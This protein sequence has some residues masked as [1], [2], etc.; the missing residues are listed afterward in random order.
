M[1]MR[2]RMCMS[3]SWT[4]MCMHIPMAPYVCCVAYASQ[5]T[6]IRKRVHSAK[7]NAP[8]LIPKKPFFLR[9]R[10]R[11]VSK[12]KEGKRRA[13]SILVTATTGANKI[14]EMVHEMASEFK[15]EGYPSTAAQ[16]VDEI[17]L[18]ILSNASLRQQFELAIANFC[19]SAEVR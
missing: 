18:L 2:M 13:K 19:S 3:M 6:M 11:G 9:W 5:A 8:N 12:V 16:R 10:F 14:E 4:Y 15:L 1:H 17:R 7:E